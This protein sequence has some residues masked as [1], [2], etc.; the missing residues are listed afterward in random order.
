MVDPNAPYKT[1]AD[2][3]QAAK[4]APGKLNYGTPGSGTSSHLAME[5]FRS[6]AGI[7]LVM[8][9]YQGSPAAL[10]D[11]MGGRIP[12]MFEAA[13]GVMSLVRSGKV[14]VIANGGAKRSAFLPDVPT[15]NESGYAGYDATPWVG[16]VAPAGTPRP[17]VDMLYTAANRYL[18]SAEG[19]ARI[20][21]MGA[22]P[23]GMNPEQFATHIRAEIER[24]GKVVAD[25]GIK[26]E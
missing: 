19:K 6:M 11:I 15:V 3:V 10:T 1:L 20:Q 8:V 12:F 2:V 26:M 16:L 14:R 25:S 17:I 22:E 21:T 5:L 18:E 7:D 23:L 4:S 24:W 13:S 9:P